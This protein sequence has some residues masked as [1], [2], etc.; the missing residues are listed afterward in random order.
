MMFLVFTAY[1]HFLLFEYIQQCL[2]Q[3]ALG[4]YQVR[5]RGKNSR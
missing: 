4:T 1:D 2:E 5:L 3:D